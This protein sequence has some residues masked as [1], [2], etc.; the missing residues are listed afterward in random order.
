[1]FRSVEVG[2]TP[3][4]TKGKRDVVVIFGSYA[5]AQSDVETAGIVLVL[6]EPVVVA[7]K[8]CGKIRSE[9]G[10]YAQVFQNVIAVSCVDG[11]R[12]IEG[13]LL[14]VARRGLELGALLC[15]VQTEVY[16][17]T[18]SAGQHVF[19]FPTERHAHFGIARETAE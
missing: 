3:V 12:E 8:T 13:V 19:A 14:D 16:E 7:G 11:Q 18:H 9:V 2:H 17:C 15:D 1:M 5:E 6:A 10:K 4:E